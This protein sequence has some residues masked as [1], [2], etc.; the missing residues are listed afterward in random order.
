LV[1]FDESDKE[2]KIQT[3]THTFKHVGHTNGTLKNFAEVPLFI[4]SKASRL[5]QMADCIAYWIYRHYES[6]DSRG[7]DLIRPYFHTSAGKQSGLSEILSGQAITELESPAVHQHPFPSPTP[8]GVTLPTVVPLLPRL[9][10][11]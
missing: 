5:I 9:A 1:I 8:L 11:S 3:L 6:R 2:R 10:H 7:M 4:D